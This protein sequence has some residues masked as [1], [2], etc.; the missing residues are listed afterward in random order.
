[1]FKKGFTDQLGRD[2]WLDSPPKRIISLVPS[3][4]ELLSALDLSDEVIGITKFCVHPDHWFRTKTR[5]GGTKNVNIDLI[6]KLR[7]DLIIANKEENTQST[8]LALCQEFPT[9]ISD[10]ATF[11]QAIQLIEQL[12]TLTHR[13]AQADKL[14]QG[15]QDEM[16]GFNPLAPPMRAAYIIWNDPVMTVGGDT[17]ISDMLE[18]AGYENVF[19]GKNRYP[20]LE[21][22]ELTNARPDLVFLSS[23]P[24]PFKQKHVLTFST[25]CPDAQ[26]VLV[27]GE[28]FSWYG[29]RLLY[30]PAYFR[31]LQDQIAAI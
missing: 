20:I 10:V 1:M 4:T 15:I 29:L 11:D 21:P 28:L 5:I 13:K 3:I 7:P 23:E 30:S 9:W 6:K 8:V 24:F 2:I 27:D 31:S 18:K 19:K 16:A 17:F 22:A 12:G 26:V 25:I 14:S